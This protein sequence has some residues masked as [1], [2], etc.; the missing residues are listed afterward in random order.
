MSLIFIEYKNFIINF[1]VELNLLITVSVLK[2][3]FSSS[4][5]C[6]RTLYLSKDETN[7]NEV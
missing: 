2:I 1:A 5:G 7:E 6:K 3:L 4:R